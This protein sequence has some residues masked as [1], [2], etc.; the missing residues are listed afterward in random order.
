MGS[1]VFEVE[2]E[3]EGTIRRG[4]ESVGEYGNGIEDA[5]LSSVSMLKCRRGDK[6]LVWDNI[7]LL[8]GLDK[9]ARQTVI[10][11]IMRAFSAEVDDAILGDV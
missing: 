3:C 9:T 11:N 1:I 2:A 7:D 5:D 6:G 10:D 8:D 4:D